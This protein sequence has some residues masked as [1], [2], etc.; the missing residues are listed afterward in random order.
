MFHLL[1]FLPCLLCICHKLL[2]PSLSMSCPLTSVS[3]C[4]STTS[5]PCCLPFLTMTLTAMHSVSHCSVTVL[6]SSLFSPL[7]QQTS[8]SG[9]HQAE[10]HTVTQIRANM[11]SQC[12]FRTH[13]P[14]TLLLSPLSYLSHK[15]RRLYPTT[16][17]PLQSQQVM[18]PP[19][20]EKSSITGYKHSRNSCVSQTYKFAFEPI[21]PFP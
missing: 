12:S 2:P 15:S 3:P 18:F 9:S 10:R 5:H 6:N 16:P 11:N 1:L 20:L 21:Y 13:H 17:G 4:P 8:N 7:S 14:G 19:P